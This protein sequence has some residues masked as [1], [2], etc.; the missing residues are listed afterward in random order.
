MMVHLRL[1]MQQATFQKSIETLWTTCPANNEF[2]GAAGR[3]A[4]AM[5]TGYRHTCVLMTGGLVACIGTNAEGELG[6]EAS[7]LWGTQDIHLGD[8]LKLVNLG[9]GRGPLLSPLNQVQVHDP[10]HNRCN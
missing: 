7:G 6:Q 10:S 4:L 2:G 8:N 1:S 3:V 5:A 9:T